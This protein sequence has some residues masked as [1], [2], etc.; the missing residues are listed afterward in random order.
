MTPVNPLSL[1]SIIIN[2]TTVR[3]MKLHTEGKETH[4]NFPNE[5]CF[6]YNLHAIG[7]ILQRVSTEDIMLV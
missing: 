6:C 3:R 1:Q 4:L 7:L 5:R 2:D